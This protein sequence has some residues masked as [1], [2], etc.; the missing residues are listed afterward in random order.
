[1]RAEDAAEYASRSAMHELLVVFVNNLR[2]AILTETEFLQKLKASKIVDEIWEKYDT[3]ASG[4]IDSS[5]LMQLISEVMEWDETGKGDGPSAEEAERFLASMDTDGN[6]VLDR[7]EFTA[8]VVN[9]LSMN[10]DLRISFAQ[11]S[12]MHAK[13]M[14]FVTNILERSYANDKL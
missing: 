12:A 7:E 5:E 3:D 6:G 2:E 11:R 8:F 10:V 13:L 4:T 9:A 1:M 14:V